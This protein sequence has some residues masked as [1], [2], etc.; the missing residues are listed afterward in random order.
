MNPIKVMGLLK[1]N[2]KYL[3]RA[4]KTNQ[5]KFFSSSDVNFNFK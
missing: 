2:L 1:S 4:L 5:T 3:I